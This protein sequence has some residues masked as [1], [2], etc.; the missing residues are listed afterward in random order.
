MI[1]RCAGASPLNV[2]APRAQSAME[3]GGLGIGVDADMDMPAGMDSP[4]GLDGA[5]RQGAPA[6]KENP[7][8]K[9][10]GE[11]STGYPVER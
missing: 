11:R 6:A 10:M 9:A 3:V 4:P 5:A 8:I 7:T 2:I 1:R